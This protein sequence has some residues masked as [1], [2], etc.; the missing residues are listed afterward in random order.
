MGYKG[1][2]LDM[3]GTLLN[4]L[5][6]IRDSVNSVISAHGYP[7]RD[8]EAYRMGVGRG[9]EHLLVEVLPREA[10]ENNALM[11][12]LTLEA[13]EV[14]RK[15]SDVKTSLYEGI[16]EMLDRLATMGVEMGI[17]TNKPQDSA[18]RC[19]D[20]YLDRWNFHAVVGASDALPLKPAPDG[21]LR[22]AGAMDLEPSEMVFLGDSEVDMAT[23][24]NAGMYP[25]GAKWGFRDAAILRASGARTVLANPCEVCGIFSEERMD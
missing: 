22:I 19:V 21:A 23:A 1:I 16:E 8:L 20:N 15:N 2:V 4:T 13:R 10:A 17:L 12:R 3:D 11:E 9:L 25:A 6:D 24:R 18:Q 7:K 14:Y 5:E